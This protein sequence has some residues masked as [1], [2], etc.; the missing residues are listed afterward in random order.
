MA[1]RFSVT[2]ETIRRDLVLLEKDGLLTRVHGGQS[3]FPAPRRCR[4]G[5]PA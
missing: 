3:Q 4:R 2:M 5:W 1:K